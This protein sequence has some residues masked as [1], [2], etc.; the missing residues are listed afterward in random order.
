[1]PRD[2][3]QGPIP[4]EAGEVTVPVW[5]A[6]Y[7]PRGSTV[8]HETWLWIGA[9]GLWLELWEARLD[10]TRPGTQWQ[11]KE[12]EK[13]LAAVRE[14]VEGGKPGGPLAVLPPDAS[15]S[16]PATLELN[17]SSPGG[18]RIRAWVNPGAPGWVVP[19]VFDVQT[20]KEIEGGPL[21]YARERVGWDAADPARL[22][23]FDG[24]VH[25]GLVRKGG[26]GK[27]KVRVELW[28]RPDAA[29]GEMR[30]LV[31]GETE[32]THWVVRVE[33]ETAGR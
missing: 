6:T 8:H 25:P 18:M 32:A 1:M 12:I 16:G 27:T 22:F 2:V 14:A 19:R 24:S 26:G 17:S 11:I 13:E 10:P 4:P 5:R 20:G 15:R 7:L 29:G 33:G 23:L 31:A 21:E 3:L 30:R 9:P 28:F